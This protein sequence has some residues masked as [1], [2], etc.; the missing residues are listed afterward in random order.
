MCENEVMWGV[1]LP[2]ALAGCSV[3]V[4]DRPRIFDFQAPTLLTTVPPDGYLAFF[5]G[6]ETLC[7]DVDHDGQLDVL[8]RGTL[9]TVVGDSSRLRWARNQGHRSLD[10]L[11]NIID[12]TGTPLQQVMQAGPLVVRENPLELSTCGGKPLVCVLNSETAVGQMS[13]ANVTIAADFLAVATS[14]APARPD[15]QIVSA[16]SFT[17]GPPLLAQFALYDVGPDGGGGQMAQPS[18][19]PLRNAIDLRV[20]DFDADGRDEL[21]QA[22]S[23]DR[24]DESLLCFFD[25]DG[26]E[27]GRIDPHAVVEAVALADVNA[28]GLLDIVLVASSGASELR[29]YLGRRDIAELISETPIAVPLGLGNVGGGALRAADLNGD[30]IVDLALLAAGQLQMLRGNG[31]GTFAEPHAITV[32]A[33]AQAIAICDLDQDGAPD[34]V[35]TGQGTVGQL[36]DGNTAV[37]FNGTAR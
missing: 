20:A 31:D 36:G 14:P 18:R 35:I 19:F 9:H 27:L 33:L 16:L 30:G 5:N 21:L 3:L 10:G 25:A 23:L 37:I 17:P 2:L 26:K 34:V 28:D 6:E 29:V 4:D 8:V 11:V 22:G 13:V 24:T 32:A 7:V 12:T 15:W 1:L